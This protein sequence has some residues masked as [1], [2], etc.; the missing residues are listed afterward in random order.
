MIYMKTFFRRVSSIS[1]VL[2]FV[3]LGLSTVTSLY[4]FTGKGLWYSDSSAVLSPFTSFSLLLMTL[5]RINRRYFSTWSTPMSLA[6]LGMVACGNFSSLWIHWFSP[7]LFLRTMPQVVPTSAMTSIGLILFCLYE[8]LISLRKTPTSAIIVDDILIHLALFPGG[9][10]LLGHVLGVPAY[11][12]S[13]IDPRVGISYAEMFLMGSFA[14][15]ATCSNPDLFLWT[16]LRRSLFNRLIFLLFFI[17]QY[18]APFLVGFLFRSSA[19]GPYQ[20]GLEFFVMLAGVMATLIFLLVSAI[21]LQ[22]NAK[23]QRV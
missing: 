16:F 13:E 17:N 2:D 11:M 10:S 19:V 4:W 20:F 1:E 9:L 18:V 6:L 3:L 7:E 15:S 12:G 5:T 22:G 14:V 8:G 21:T 23:L